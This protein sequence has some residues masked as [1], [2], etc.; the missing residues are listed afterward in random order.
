MIEQVKQFVVEQLHNNEFFKGGAAIAVLSALG[1][2]LKSFF[3]WIWGRIKRQFSYTMRI[4]SKTEIYNIFNEWLRDNH[5]DKYKKVILSVKR[6]DHDNIGSRDEERTYSVKENNFESAFYFWQNRTPVFLESS[7]EKMENASYLENAHIESYTLTTYFN[8]NTLKNLLNEV[9]NEY[10]S[11]QKKKTQS[12]LY[13][14]RNYNGWDKTGVIEVK[15]FDKIFNS[16]KIELLDDINDFFESKEYY[17]ERGIPYRRGYLADG[18]PGNGKT[19]TILSIAQKLGKD[20]YS[21]N[22]ASLTDSDQLRMAFNTIKENTFLLLEDIDC[23]VDD[24]EKINEKINFSTV[25][26]VLDGAYSKKGICTFF[27][28]NH[29][30]QLDSALT[31]CGRMDKK[32]TFNNPKKEDVEGMLELF[33]GEKKELENYNETHSAAQLQEFFIKS[34]T[35]EEAINKII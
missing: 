30:D 33:F 17:L 21:L 8:R 14:Y 22:I 2:W 9:V 23:V 25:L 13:D 31:R 5:S 18:I 12:Y 11:K 20:V 15:P 32:I 26:N 4:E 35:I 1:F 3:P 19:T 7:R 27:T 24:R 28:S 6:D 10:N 34:N 29:A 16:E